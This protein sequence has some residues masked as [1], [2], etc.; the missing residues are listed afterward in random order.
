MPAKDLWSQ[1]QKQ[2]R[3]RSE[4]EQLRILRRHLGELHDE[5]KGPYKDLRDKLRKL[6]ARLEGHEATRSRSGQQDP[7]HVKSQG[8]ARVVV[9]GLPNAGKSSLVGALTGAATPVADYPFT[10]TQPSPGML[11]C[12]GGVLQLVDTP[13]IVEGLASGQ[14]AGR[15]LLHLFT[16]ADALAIVVDLST[17]VLDSLATILEELTSVSIRPVPGPLATVLQP[18][19]KGGVRF[20][21]KPLG[22]E[23]EEEARTVLADAHIVN[24]EVVVRTAFD[25]DQ[26]R[27]QVEGELLMPTVL[28]ATHCDSETGEQETLQEMMPGHDILVGQLQQPETLGNVGGALLKVLGYTHI[29]LLARPAPEAKEETLLLHL[30]SDILRVA[31]RGK[32][33]TKRLKGARVWGTS[34]PRPGQAVRLDHVVDAG[35]RVFLQS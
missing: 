4:D 28:V 32:I 7:F 29:Q 10:T 1:I 35:D 3:G 12:E 16:S 15:P 13:P 26:L 17:D 20:L 9:A 11:P 24:A 19:G 33:S 23:E 14:G 6:V 25:I 34:V 5:W 30:A 18:R 31:E 21:G 8:D 2:T 22:R 27:H